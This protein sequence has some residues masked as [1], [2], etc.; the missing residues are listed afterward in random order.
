MGIRCGYVTWFG[1]S[2]VQD[3]WCRPPYGDGHTKFLHLSRVLRQKIQCI[4]NGSDT[5]RGVSQLS[6]TFVPC[7]T[8][9]KHGLSPRLRDRSGGVSALY[10]S[11]NLSMAPCRSSYSIQVHDQAAV[12]SFNA[13][14]LYKDAG[15]LYITT[16]KK[17]FIGDTET[18]LHP[19]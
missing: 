15:N 2:G 16:Y 8:E 18:H 19:P 1:G 9:M 10:T 17:T 6:C 3:F 4:S 11:W 5:A 7:R 13:C 14:Y 12:I